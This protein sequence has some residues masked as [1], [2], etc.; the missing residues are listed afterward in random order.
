MPSP[1]E[2]YALIGDC[3]TA[4]LVSRDGSIDWLCWPRFDSEACFAAL[5]GTPEHG[6]W[7]VS[8]RQQAKIT[9][10]YRPGHADS[11]NQLRDR[12]RRSDADRFYA[13]PF[14]SFGDRAHCG[15]HSRHGRD[16]NRVRLA[17]WIWRRGA[18]GH[19]DR[20]RL[21]AR[22]RRPGYD[23]LAHACASQRQGHD[24]SWRVHRQPRRNCSVDPDLFTFT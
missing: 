2:D 17:L 21:A 14:R 24:H 10:R 8:P 6:R 20:G 1:I 16:A 15:R 9:R 19:Q 4:A 5:L 7:L 13:V 23:G 18:L 22:D 12:R 3:K 11:R